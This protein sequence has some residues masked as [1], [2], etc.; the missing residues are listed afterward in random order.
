MSPGK[1]REQR[2]FLS[3]KQKLA[4][5][6]KKKDDQPFTLKQQKR[7]QRNVYALIRNQLL[8]AYDSSSLEE[9][10][11][12]AQKLV[13]EVRFFQEMRSEQIILLAENLTTE[14]LLLRKERTRFQRLPLSQLSRWITTI[15]TLGLNR[16]RVVIL[17]AVIWC[18]NFFKGTV[19]QQ[20]VIK[21]TGYS[22]NTI[23][24]HLKYLLSKGLLIEEPLNPDQSATKTKKK[25]A[26]NKF[27]DMNRRQLKSNLPSPIK[28]NSVVPIIDKDRLEQAYICELDLFDNLDWREVVGYQHSKPIVKKNPFI[29]RNAKSMIIHE[30]VFSPQ[31]LLFC[32]LSEAE[33]LSWLKM[34]YKVPADAF[35]SLLDEMTERIESCFINSEPV[36]TNAHFT[37]IEDALP[38]L[39]YSGI[40][41]FRIDF[42]HF[43]YLRFFN[44]YL[45]KTEQKALIERN[46]EMAISDSRFGWDVDYFVKCLHKKKPGKHWL[47]RYPETPLV[48]AGNSMAEFLRD[49]VMI[50][51]EW[52]L[53]ELQ[54]FL[55]R[56]AD[57]GIITNLINASKASVVINRLEK[58][59]KKTKL[60]SLSFRPSIIS[61]IT[62]ANFLSK[63]S[64]QNL[65]KM[66]RQ[67]LVARPGYNFLWVDVSQMH[68]SILLA[69]GA[70]QLPACSPKGE[71]GSMLEELAKII[72][73]D[74][75]A[76][77]KA[78]YPMLNAAGKK[79]V[80]Q[81]SGLSKDQLNTLLEALDEIPAYR[82]FYTWVN[83]YAAIH[84]MTPLT[85]LGFQV[86]VY[87]NNR[88]AA[89]HTVHLAANEV[90]RQWLVMLD[91]I[92]LSSYIVNLVHDEIVFQVP[93]ST[94]P[95]TFTRKAYEALNR[96]GRSLI[97]GLKL[98]VK[99][100][101]GKSWDEFNAIEIVPETKTQ[102]WYAFNRSCSR[103]VSP[104]VLSN[105]ITASRSF[106]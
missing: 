32:L 82:E 50:P 64:P 86:P 106:L 92:N 90:F 47:K 43:Q 18:E 104:L 14:S 25:K 80:R 81:V 21:H 91:E 79:K 39:R 98:G 22:K 44:P 103:F 58:H 99:A 33:I 95:Y 40:R 2:V 69:L 8:A 65:P 105:K 30:A 74:R 54:R 6:L 7:A 55:P 76:I 94:N 10:H 15:M 63:S 38:L 36:S 5:I 12:F 31:F 85:P 59:M 37:Q 101:L 66:I 62:H 57:R 96:A 35:V 102:P 93:A 51:P 73:A 45:I 48:F 97:P 70:N 17:M 1:R 53:D 46:K 16:Q 78:I 29:V 4:R 100:S 28:R 61:T 84:H 89:G 68:L 72:G 27:I 88:L 52:D 83:G 67:L 24:T 77:K 71:F 87:P 42:D 49:P 13:K 9:L 3:Y 41:E 56:M 75:K 60:F 26:S 11:L 23:K 20:L 19:S 34:A